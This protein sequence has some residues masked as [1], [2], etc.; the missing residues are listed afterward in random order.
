M[1]NILSIGQTALSAAQAGLATTGHNIANAATPG[2]SRQV[3]IQAS[4]GSQ[5]LGTG[6]IGKGVNVSDVKRVYN[7][8]LAGQVRTAQSSQVQSET[9]YSQVR[10]LD[11]MLGDTDG[12]VSPAL[13]DFFDGIQD[14]ASNVNTT[15]ARQNALSTAET[16]AARFHSLDGQ[17]KE[18]ADGVNSQ[19][20]SSVTSVN[21]YAVQIAKLNDAIEKTMGNSEG[22]VPNDLLD[23][24]DHAVSELSKEIKVNLVKQGNSYNVFIGNGQPLV[25]GTKPQPLVMTASATDQSRLEIG[26][27]SNTGATVRLDESMFTGGRLGGLFSFRS[28]SLDTA[29]NSLGRVA[30]GLAA[31]FNEQHKLGQ[32]LS[33]TLGGDFF[34]VGS[35]RVDANIQNDQTVPVGDVDAVITDAGKLTTSDYR[36]RFDGTNYMVTR[37]SDGT[38]LYNNTAFPQGVEFDGVTLSQAS[39]LRSGDEFLIRPT[40]DGAAGF[41]VAIKDVAKIAG[42]LP[43][44]TS[45]A[46]TNTGSGLIG[47]AAV[48]STV[49]LRSPALSLTHNGAAAPGGTLTGF[50]ANLPFSVTSGGVTT[51]Y[52]AGTSG[53]L[54]YNAG[55]TLN[56]G[57]VNL[58]VPTTAGAHTI[59]APYSTL[60]YSAGNL[61]GFPADTDINVKH[62]DGSVTNYTGVTALTAVA[63]QDGDTFSY[64]GISF[65]MTGTPADNDRFT[66]AG[67]NGGVSDTR[68]A[69]LLGQLQTTNTL[70]NGSTSYQG[71]Y[72]Q[73]VSQIGN[74]TR[75]ME[76]TNSAESAYLEQAV[77][78]H[79]NESGVNLDEEATNL[80]RYQQAYQAAAKVMQTASTLFDTLLSLGN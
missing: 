7:E 71:A 18:I 9:Y 23:Q 47:A 39:T 42:G 22:K 70:A 67:N 46:S 69:L 2:Y 13:Q 77:A 51:D 48:D 28:N 32:D 21:N 12:G 4:N 55:D 59:S 56:I 6:Y 66:V 27:Q 52:P 15:E 44:K 76:V 16:L 37:M 54:A 35:P 10:M 57:G 68:N 62:A 11:N 3:V 78:A 20:K 26:Y 30:I 24:R 19:I 1:A 36:V 80:L 41:A 17:L 33:G 74:K 75:E 65:T 79:E 50:P 58:S 14:L 5:S 45:A 49:L 25:V 31:T 72:A 64:G 34:S 73:L 60:T 61:T 29:R 63:Y 38:D 43:T 53:P 40:V 8:L